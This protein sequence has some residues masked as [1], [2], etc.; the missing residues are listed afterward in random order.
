MTLS[1]PPFGIPKSGKVAFDPGEEDQAKLLDELKEKAR[2]LGADGIIDIQVGIEPQW[3]FP[4]AMFPLVHT[5]K[6]K[7]V[8]SAVRLK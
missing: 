1:I 2:E 7:M 6:T 3:A 4:L 8:G 5:T